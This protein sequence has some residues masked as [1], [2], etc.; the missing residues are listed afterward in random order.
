MMPERPHNDNPR[1]RSLCTPVMGLCAVS[2][3]LGSFARPAGAAGYFTIQ[4]IDAATGRGV[5]LV[6]LRTVNKATWW[7][8]SNGIVAFDEPGLMDLEVFFHVSSPGYEVPADFFHNRGVK[9]MPRRGGSAVIRIHRLNIA[10]R[11]YRIT[12]QG[13]YRDSVLVGRSVPLKQ[14]VLNGQVMGQDTVIAAPYRGKI[15]WFWGDTDRAS[16]PLG[17]F[18]ASGATSELPGHGGLD[19]GVGVDLTYFVD[20][21]GFSKPM[22]PLPKGGLHWIESLFTVPDEQGVERLVARMANMP[23]LGAATDYH[24]MLFNDDQEVFEPIQRWDIHDPHASAHPFVACV[25]GVRYFYIYPDIRV[26]ADWKSLADLGRYEVFTCLADAGRWHGRETEVDR[27]ASGR[28]RYT[29]KAGADRL[30]GGHFH[31]LVAAGKLRREET[32][33]YLLDMDTGAP[34]TRGLA[35]VAWNEFRQRWIAFFADKSGEVWFSEADTPLG[36]WG[37][38]RRVVTHGEYNFYNIAHHPFFDQDRGRLVYFEGTYTAAFT[39]AADKGTLTPRYDYNQL[40]YRLALDDARLILPMAVYRVRGTTGATHLWLRDRVDAAGAWERVEQVAFFAL[41]PTPKGDEAVPVYA[42]EKDGTVLSTTPSEPNARPTFVGWPLIRQEPVATIQ[43]LWDCRASTMGGDELEFPLEFSLQGETVQG[44][45]ST[46]DASGAGVFHAGKLTQTLKT[47]EGTFIFEG[48][49]EA[50][51]L[52]GTWQ[53]EGAP[54]HGTWSASPVD[55]TPAE[56]R[57]PALVVLW[58]YRRR[59]DGGRCYS[60]EPQPPADCDLAGRPLCRV[61]KVPGSAPAWD[62]KARPVADRSR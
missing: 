36:P 61:W 49:L 23:G 22:C 48:H 32:W 41:P 34:L 25:D 33:S 20:E 60:T 27:D 47:Q 42:V 45:S 14:P 52:T 1:L 43:G 59:A 26:P 31:D 62:W 7:T 44:R 5:P 46:L 3:L 19:P 50:R 29:W 24:L 55:T 11:L 38:G 10:E 17:N 28:I 53:Q 56:R 54:R 12:G 39:Q 51:I 21:S 18:G 9:L 8:D 35:S 15:Y 37:Y 16:Y 6:E 13:I 30:R 58:E 2:L 40:M 4:V 57:S